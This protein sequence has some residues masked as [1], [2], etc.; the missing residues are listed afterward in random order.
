MSRPICSECG[1]PLPA[2][3]PEESCP[4]CLLLLG[5]NHSVEVTALISPDALPAELAP[6]SS[7]RTEQ[8]GQRIGRYKLLE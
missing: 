3:V 7:S 8:S 1:G 4:R 5:G 6:E 2:G